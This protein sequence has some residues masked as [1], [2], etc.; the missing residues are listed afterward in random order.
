MDVSHAHSGQGAA[1]VSSSDL[2]P[3]II[4]DRFDESRR[5]DQCRNLNSAHTYQIAT[6]TPPMLEHAGSNRALD[7]ITSWKARVAL[8]ASHTILEPLSTRITPLSSCRRENEIPRLETS[9]YFER[10]VL[11]QAAQAAN[12]E[13]L[14]EVSSSIGSRTLPNADPPSSDSNTL[15]RIYSAL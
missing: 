6:S 14:V 4:H 1:R 7:T 2:Q 13:F 10:V 8:S 12:K 11:I 15:L 9:P 3:S 5:M